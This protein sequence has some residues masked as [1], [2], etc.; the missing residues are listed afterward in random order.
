[1]VSIVRFNGRPAIFFFLSRA[2]R[3]QNLFREGAR[4][5]DHPGFD[6]GS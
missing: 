1:M 6:F 3:K 2:D 5:D 4:H